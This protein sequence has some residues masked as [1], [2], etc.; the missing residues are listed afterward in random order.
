MDLGS[1]VL[2]AETALELL[3]EEER[4][5]VRLCP[6]PLVE[7]A[8]AA[9]V[10]IAA[11][12]D[13]EQCSG[14]PPRRW[15]PRPGI[16]SAPRRP[17][18]RPGPAPPAADFLEATVTLR[19]THGLHLR[20]AA[21]LV[22]AAA[23]FRAEVLVGRPA[24]G[25]PPV[26]AASLNAVAT[27]G[28][29]Q[30]EQVLFRA[31][32]PEARQALDALCRLAAERFGEGSAAEAPES[33]PAPAPVAVGTACL[34]GIPVS[35]GFAAGLLQQLQHSLLQP[36]ARPPLEPEREWAG[37]QAA[38]AAEREYLSSESRSAGPG[39]RK[40][41]LLEAF[42]LILEDP[43]LLDPVREALF[44]RGRN[45]E[46]ALDEGIRAMAGRF[47]GLADAY[48]RER[49]ADV[50]DLGQR[51]LRRLRRG[52]PS[53]ERG[54]RQ[55]AVP[56]AASGPVLLAAEE[57]F[58]TDAAG[59]EPQAV[60]GVLTVRGGATSHA[61]VLVRSLGIP[62]IT[63]LPESLLRLP[64]GTP[65]AMDGGRGRLW[66]G[67]D[68][69]TLALVESG[70]AGWLRRREA[71]AAAARQPAVS[72]DGRRFLVEANIAGIADARQAVAQGGEGVG[73]LRT[74]FLYLRRAVPPSEEEQAQTLRE[75]AEAL[76]GRPLTVRTLDVGGDKEL[77]YLALAGGGQPLPGGPRDP[78]GT[79]A[80]RAA[81]Q[82][83]AR[84]AAGGGRA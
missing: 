28:L 22:R 69:P 26:P 44:E 61:S 65:A 4:A 66:I 79:E 39:A 77:P 13:L 25:Q 34:Q 30:G 78:P 64:S 57:L 16:C 50:L 72:R 71:E 40:A 23:G 27:L 2:A 73:V 68:A 29:G 15:P 10:Q 35:E 83:A 76:Q 11:G 3:S 63:G 1:A 12:A 58:A 49:G 43:A 67:P 80:A 41:E 62:C 51:V 5:G 21:R 59:L 60:L 54:E 42:R 47:R 36:S 75:I 52:V 81:A 53:A 9:A 18:R 6:A 17:F 19:N 70:R 33:A 38:L 74:E 55:P 84:R 14:R 46:Q 8:V 48:A 37:L 20:P 32:G 24:S 82:P 45:A 31:R 56:P 7:G